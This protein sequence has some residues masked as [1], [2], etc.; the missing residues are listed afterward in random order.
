MDFPHCAD[1]SSPSR[2]HAGDGKGIDFFAVFVRSLKPTLLKLCKNSA[3][4]A[5]PVIPFTRLSI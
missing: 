5:L 2:E 1:S 4:R 3:F